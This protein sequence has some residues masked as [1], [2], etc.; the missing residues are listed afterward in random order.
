MTANRFIL[1]LLLNSYCM[2]AAQQRPSLLQELGKCKIE[3][4]LKYV[5]KLICEVIIC[6]KKSLDKKIICF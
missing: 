3:T 2:Y 1:D 6:K 5:F 4:L